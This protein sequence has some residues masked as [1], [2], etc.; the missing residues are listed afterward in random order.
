MPQYNSTT[1]EVSSLSSVPSGEEV[2]GC[3][4]PWSE[5]AEDTGELSSAV[6]SRWV[7]KRR[8]LP[9]SLPH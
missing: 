4:H 1:G 2:E 7:G 5:E 3:A 8:A 6:V 9:S